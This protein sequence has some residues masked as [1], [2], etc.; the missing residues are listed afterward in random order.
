M[1]PN[2]GAIGPLIVHS[3]SATRTSGSAPQPTAG[4]DGEELPATAAGIAYAN[5]LHPPV[6]PEGGYRDPHDDPDNDPD[7]QEQHP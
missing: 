3:C 7:D 4:K 5:D 6:D 2:R 1:A